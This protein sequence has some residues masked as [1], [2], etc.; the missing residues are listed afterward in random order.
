VLM[1]ELFNRGSTSVGVT[2]RKVDGTKFESAL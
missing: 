1:I 2:T